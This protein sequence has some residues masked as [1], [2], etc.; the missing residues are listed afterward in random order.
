MYGMDTGS[1]SASIVGALLWPVT[2]SLMGG[3]LSRFKCV[4]DHFGGPFQRNILGGCIFI[5]AKDVFNL[6][7]RYERIR[8]YRSRHV[9]DYNEIIKRKAHQ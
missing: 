4:R 8:Q 6:I 2:S 3:F 7:Y 5:L 9:M 1:T